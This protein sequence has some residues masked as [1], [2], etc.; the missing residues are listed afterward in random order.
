M[1]ATKMWNSIPAAQQTVDS[2]KKIWAKVMTPPHIADPTKPLPSEKDMDAYDLAKK[3]SDR[4]D[5]VAQKASGF[6]KK[7][8]PSEEIK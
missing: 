3:Y 4:D 2:A 8:L 1:A 5:D 6:V 7:Y